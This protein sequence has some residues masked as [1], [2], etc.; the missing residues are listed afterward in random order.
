MA[1]YSDGNQLRIR[2]A[3]I[4]L[5]TEHAEEMVG[6]SAENHGEHDQEQ[7]R[8]KV[9]RLR[10]GFG[11]DGK[12][13]DEQAER[14]QADNRQ[15]ADDERCARLRH[16]SRHAAD[17]IHAQRPEVVADV[18]GA[19]K[20][21]RLC[22]RVIERMQQRAEKPQRPS[23]S[24]ADGDD[25]HVLD[26]AVGHQTFQIPLHQNEQA[27][28]NHGHHAKDQQQRM[29]KSGSGGAG[30]DRVIAHHRIHGAIEQNGREQS[31]D[32]VW[33]LRRAHPAASYAW[34]RS[35]S[36]FRSRR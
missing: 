14:R 27:G 18:S 24:Q 28:D 19:E 8:H 1:V 23:Q 9:A 33:E 15:A 30:N 36:S 29:R 13:A 31:A 5:S 32:R 10:E 12:L 34:E 3:L 22:D 7:S 21:K 4:G 17:P 26:T 11:Q 6:E 2:R 25:S 16:G 20:E 35:R